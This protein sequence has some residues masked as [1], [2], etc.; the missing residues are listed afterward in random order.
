M[1][2]IFSQENKMK[3]LAQ[4]MKNYGNNSKFKNRKYDDA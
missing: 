1:K 3:K 2:S 4:K